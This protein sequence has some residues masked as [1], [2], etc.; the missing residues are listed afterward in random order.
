MYVAFSL[1]PW[2]L[3][4]EKMNYLAHIH[5]SNNSDENMLGNFLKDFPSQSTL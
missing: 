5:L 4:G 1:V 3:K 2:D